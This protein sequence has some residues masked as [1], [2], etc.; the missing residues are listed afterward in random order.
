M[1]KKSIIKEVNEDEHNTTKLK[2][3]PPP[4]EEGGSFDVRFIKF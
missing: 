2:I 3:K 1:M 4:F